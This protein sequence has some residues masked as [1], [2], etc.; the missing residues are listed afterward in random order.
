MLEYFIMGF[1]EAL[2]QYEAA[3]VLARSQRE[4]E[5]S[6]KRETERVLHERRRQQARIVQQ[7]SGVYILVRDFRSFLL[8]SFRNIGGDQRNSW[9]PDSAC[10]GV[11]WDER[12]TGVEVVYLLATREEFAREKRMDRYKAKFIMIE[13]QPDGNIIFHAAGV[14]TVSEQEWKD[15]KDA[16]G[17]ALARAYKNPAIT[18]RYGPPEIHEI[19]PIP[20]D[21]YPTPRL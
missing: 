15:N 7:D 5:L 1:I 18:V 17:L 16:L 6:R 14:T 2:G 12:K 21:Y 9:D 13:S 3:E 20:L 10:Q 19:K 11:E 4:A 8:E